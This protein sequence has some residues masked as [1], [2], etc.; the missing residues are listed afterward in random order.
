MF[1][2]L[3]IPSHFDASRVGTVWRVPYQERAAQARAWAQQH[4]IPPAANDSFRICLIA[5]DVQNTFCVPDFELY[6]GG[7]SGTGAVD[8]T[9]RLC[10]FIYRNLAHITQIVPTMDTHQAA[11][12]FH[13]LFLVNERGEHPAP[14]TLITA[15]QVQ[16]GA[17][18]INPAIATSLGISVEEGQRHLEHYTRQLEQSGKYALTIWPYHAML[19]GIGHALVSAFEEAVFFHSIARYSQ[20]DFHV[21]GNAPLTEH[22]SV[23]GPEVQV[24]YDGKPLAL[25]DEKILRKLETFDAIIIA[26]K[27]RATASPGRLPICSMTCARAMRPSRAKCTCSKI[28]HRRSLSPARWITPPKPM[29]RSSDLPTRECT[30]SAPPI[31]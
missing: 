22:Y 10:E 15:D 5:V 8:D 28:A 6:V 20:P 11:Q 19:G 29:R 4:H 12:I 26:A 30:S 14:F 31:R 1:R 16:R 2:E 7:R 9:R 27:P 25:K 17:W 18:R 24:G 21:K 23:L 13:A 3:A